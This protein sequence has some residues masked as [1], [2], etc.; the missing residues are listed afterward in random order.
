LEPNVHF[1][2]DLT[3]A[4][5]AA[6]V[7]GWLA[8]RLGLDSIVGYLIAGIAI[9][10][11]TPGYVAEKQTLGNLAELGLIFLLFS[12]G[13]R[14]SFRE[15]V[16][17]G[18][19]AIAASLAVMAAFAGAFWAAA[20]AF[21]FPHPWTLAIAAVVSSTAIGVALLRQWGIEERRSGQF[22]IALLIVQDLVAVALLVIT[23]APGTSLSVSGIVLPM[24][25]AIGFVAIALVAGA[26]VLHVAVVRVLQYMP[27]EALFG[28]FAALALIAAW[29]AHLAGLPFDF[30]AFVAGAV[31]SEAAASRMVHAIVAPFQALFAAIFFVSIGTLLDPGRALE[32]W[33]PI[34]A[35]GSAFMLLRFAGWSAV[36]RLGGFPA[37]KALLMGV[38]MVPLGEFNI[39]LGN[40]AFTAS[41]VTD[42]ER[43]VLLGLTFYSIL[44]ATG[45]APALGRLRAKF[46]VETV[47]VEGHAAAAEVVVIGFGRVGRAVAHA[48][49]RCEIPFAVIER[50]RALVALARGQGI[51]AV[52]GDGSDPRALD[53]AVTPA[54]RVIV[55][56]TPETV[57]NAAV[58]RRYGARPETLVIAR[59]THHDDIAG[60]LRGGAVRALVPETEGALAFAAAALRGLDVS[61]ERIAR[62]IAVQRKE[63][64]LDEELDAAPD[65]AAAANPAP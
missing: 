52:L 3:V 39:V 34:L 49:A 28:T 17:A 14:F 54:T 9:G 30:G 56:T 48:L 27:T 32:A 36:S 43:T 7:G 18:A 19:A 45:A 53:A 11:F 4:L 57:T 58:A 64:E 21:H 22:V 46:D 26:T 63:M 8:R 42:A 13:L 23:S 60:L 38:A 41:R 35:I 37:R 25:F 55:A 1:L 5:T 59:A 24:I 61:D 2:G 16:S 50:D 29:L 47:E 20:S 40:A 12:I 33:Q 15:L 65:S 62:E 10:P 51:E 44:A 6:V 31:I